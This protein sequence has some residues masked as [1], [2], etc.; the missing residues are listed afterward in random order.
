MRD[1]APWLLIGLAA[2][3]MAV[4]WYL[5]D[6]HY[7]AVHQ[8]G[9]ELGSLCDINETLS[10]TKVNASKWSSLPL[11]EG[12]AELPISLP[13]LAF[14]ALVLL[15]GWLARGARRQAAL[16]AVL[17]LSVPALAFS[18]FLVGVQAFALGA[19]C[20]FCLVLDAATLGA[21]LV[22]R[23]GYDGPLR[24][25]LG[26]AF[27]DR[28]T[29]RDLGLAFLVVLGLGYGRYADRVGEV[30]P[31]PKMAASS[32]PK[33]EREEMS[34]E[35]R[36]KALTEAR[37]AIGQFYSAW[38]GIEPKSI[39]EQPFDA[40][41]GNPAADIVLVEFADF[42]CPHCKLTGYFLKDIAH[43]YGDW[44]RFTFKNYPLGQKCN[45]NMARD[46]HPDACAAAVAAQCAKRQAKF[47]EMHDLNFD[48]QGSLGRKKLLQSAQS[49]GLDLPAFEECLDKE[50][51]WDEVKQ[52]VR[53]GQSVGIQGTPTVFINGKELP[54]PHPLMIEAA[55]RTEMKARGLGPLPV[56]ADG[57][58]GD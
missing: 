43:R 6:V 29:L 9:L 56:D 37:D 23:A 54:S 10:C 8:A 32:T 30:A 48:N 39:P 25:A 18:L 34:P 47:W 1:K 20:P 26:A 42:E 41:K 22:A 14:H 55:L 13:G 31:A 7:N 2:L 51:L 36:E 45:Q 52:Q 3:G 58:F 16:A 53:D 35:E 40:S 17:V 27:G 50:S 57:L 38:P 15:A 44:V 11:G 19:W 33:P 28:G 5:T 21:F 46:L 12:R 49:L 24:G 4:S